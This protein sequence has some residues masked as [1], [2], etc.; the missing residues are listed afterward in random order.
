MPVTHQEIADIA[1]VSRVAVSQVLHKSRRSRISPEKQREI[2][3]IA[4]RMGYKPRNLT[5]HTVGYVVPSHAFSLSGE[6]Q[7]LRRVDQAL[8]DAG[9]RLL[10]TSI[11][12]DDL[13]TL[14]DILTPK[15]VDAVIYTRWFG[16]K[17][18]NLLPAEIPWVITSDDDA[19]PSNFDQIVMDTAETA[20]RI[21]HHLA[22]FGHRRICVISAPGEGGVTSHVKKGAD[23]ALREAGLPAEGLSSIEVGSDREIGGQ[24]LPLL[25]KRNA[26]TAYLP[27][28]AEKALTLLHILAG[29]G[30]SVPGDVSVVSLLDSYMFEPLHPPVTSTTAMAASLA[31]SVVGRLLEKLSDE[32]S[33]ARR[34]AV[35]GEIIVRESVGPAKTET[36]KK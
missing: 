6:N 2:E 4:R 25:K 1:G 34:V 13:T 27:A 16:G 24:L 26:P 23:L 8:R 15:T 5:T 14:T 35:P 32:S 19:V 22:G 7:F 12:D 17:I 9:Y 30:L 31:Q 29:A 3:R 36:K 28:S 21:V 11:D 33:A 10:L 18:V 20:R